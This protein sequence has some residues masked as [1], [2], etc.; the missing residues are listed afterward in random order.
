MHIV[1]LKRLKGFWEKHQDAET[2]LRAWYRVA[3]QASWTSLV[4]VRKTYPSADYVDGLTVFN[5]SGNKYRLIVTIRY[6]KG[7]IFIRHVLTHAEYDQ[8]DWRK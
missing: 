5:I 8:G 6:K 3:K 2:P 1:S 7:R 4:D